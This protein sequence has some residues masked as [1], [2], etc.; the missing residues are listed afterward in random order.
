MTNQVR[1]NKR[2]FLSTEIFI[3]RAIAKHGKKYIYHDFEYRN[4]KTRVKVTCPEHGDFFPVIDAHLRGGQCPKCARALVG[5]KT[6]KKPTNFL[7]QAKAKHGDKYL[8]PDPYVSAH[9]ELR[10]I[11][12]VH[13]DFFQVPHSHLKGSGC[14]KCAA[15]Q[16]GIR[17]SQKYR[18]RFIEQ[19][20]QVH[21]KKYIYSFTRILNSHSK[22]KI[23]CP[24]HGIFSQL[25]H[26]HLNGSGCPVCS[27]E[28]RGLSKTDTTESFIAKARQVHGDDYDYSEVNYTGTW[29]EVTIT[30]K[31]HGKFQSIP[32]S[33]INQKSGCPKCALFPIAASTGESELA[34]LLEQITPIKRNCRDLIFPKEIDIVLPEFKLGIEY[35]GLYWHSDKNKPNNYHED[36]L[37]QANN[38]GY[39]LIHVFEDEWRDKPAIIKSIISNRLGVNQQKI[40]ARNTKIKQVGCDEAKGFLDDNHIQG[41]VWAEIRIGLFYEDNLVMLIQFSRKKTGA[42]NPLAHDWYELTRLCGK[43]GTTIVGGFSKLLKHFIET[44]HPAGIKTYCDKRWFNG[45]GYEKVGFVKTHDVPPNYCYVIGKNRVS[46]R[47]FQRKHLAKRLNKFN[48][49]QSERENMEANGYSR[50]FDC[51]MIAYSWSPQ[52]N[53]YRN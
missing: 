17:I 1:S 31:L 13:G 5:L 7:E 21:N 37:K 50:I 32:N 20:N 30:C 39:G 22:I 12:K 28:Q 29:N 11:C 4:N 9:T 35:C 14:K 33:H 43:L 45:K 3:A 25:A 27:Y 26:D 2:E 53:P 6:R 24:K 19:A 48:P 41:N 10:I 8:Y 42:R 34:D 38:A 15:L 36:K 49:S 40:Y 18:E 51:G 46:K 16:N 47:L 44:H 52:K 23:I